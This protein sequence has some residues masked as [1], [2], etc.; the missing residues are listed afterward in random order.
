MVLY[1]NERKNGSNTGSQHPGVCAT[2]AIHDQAKMQ[3]QHR[4]PII[5][6][7]NEE[8]V[9]VIWRKRQ[10]KAVWLQHWR[11]KLQLE[12]G[13]TS[14]DVEKMITSVQEDRGKLTGEY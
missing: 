13:M 6:P 10:T 7:E 4:E 5:L 3:N 11:H 9:A 14:D 12:L 2:P 1:L 8:E